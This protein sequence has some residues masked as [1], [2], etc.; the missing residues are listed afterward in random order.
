IP[1]YKCRSADIKTLAGIVIIAI[2]CHLTAA[3]PSERVNLLSQLLEGWDAQEEKMG[4]EEVTAEALTFLIVGLD[5]TSNSTCAI[6]YY[7]ALNLHTQSKLQHELDT[8]LSSHSP[9][10]TPMSDQLRP[11]TLPYLNVCINEALC[12]HLTS[13]LGLPCVVPAG[14]LSVLR[15]SFKE[16]MVLSVPSYSVHRDKAVW[17]KDVE[18][19]RPERWFEG[20]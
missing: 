5:T 6:I 15:Q 17:G 19:F 16:G 14:G 10:S 4:R 1:W 20:E 18:V 9:S 8:C 2:A 12:L 7:L 3:N 13:A 11:M